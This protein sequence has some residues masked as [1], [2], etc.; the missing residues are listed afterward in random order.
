MD[1]T[2]SSGRGPVATEIE[3][4]SSTRAPDGRQG[5]PSRRC[6]VTSSQQKNPG[7]SSGEATPVPIPNTAVKLSSAEDTERAAF[8]ENRSSPGFF[9]SPDAGPTSTATLV[10]RGLRSAA[11]AGDRLVDDRRPAQT[12]RRRASVDGA[13]AGWTAAARGRRGAA[14][15]ASARGRLSLPV[16]ARAASGGPRARSVSIAAWRSSADRRAS[17]ETQRS[18]CLTAAYTTC[19]RFEAALDARVGALDRARRRAWPPSRRA[20]PDGCHASPR[21]RS[22][23]RAPSPARS[24]C[25]AA[26]GAWRASPWPRPWSAPP[27]LLLAARFAG[28][29]RRRRRE[30][31]R[32][33][34]CRRRS[35]RRPRRWR[36]RPPRR[37]CR[38]PRRP[39]RRPA[40]APA[41]TPKPTAKPAATRRYKV[42]SGDTL[43]GIASALR[44][45]RRRPQEAQQHQRREPH[46]AGPGP[47]HPLSAGSA[48]R[49]RTARLSAGSR[50]RSWSR[51]RPARSR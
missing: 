42:K 47:A 12:L 40:R 35:H 20:S 39:A 10:R 16:R 51:S 43:S 28:G 22:I 9:A 36:H 8:R 4:P 44:H 6:R 46:P 48:P 50:G 17:L 23:G 11:D 13:G 5:A 21:S 14:R 38:R 25:S 1:P 3:D 49:P 18:L 33:R 19:P 26:A 2:V 7:D 41:K 15:G 27:A 45:H 32:R 34:R 30:P 31:A 29:G 24:R 37:R